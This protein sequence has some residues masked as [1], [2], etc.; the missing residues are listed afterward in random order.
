MPLYRAWIPSKLDALPLPLRD[1]VRLPRRVR[2]G[3]RERLHDSVFP[4][5]SAVRNGANG[6]PPGAA[7]PGTA[8]APGILPPPPIVNSPPNGPALLKALRRRWLLASVSSIVGGAIVAAAMFMFVPPSKHTVQ[9]QFELDAAPTDPFGK[10]AP[11]STNA[12]MFRTAQA[13]RLKSK[14]VIDSAM[15]D[16]KVA[17]LSI[18]RDVPDMVAWVNRELRLST[19]GGDEFLM[20]TL[21][22]D[23]PDEGQ[24]FLNAIVRAYLAEFINAESDLRK[25]K[26]DNLTAVKNRYDADEVQRRELMKQWSKD[27]GNNAEA[28]AYRQTIIQRALNIY[29]ENSIK[30][31]NEIAQ[32]KI[33]LKS[34]KERDPTSLPLDDQTF[35]EFFAKDQT[36]ATLKKNADES[37]ATLIDYQATM[38]PGTPKIESQKAATAAADGEL[39]LRM[40]A[41]RPQAELFWREKTSRIHA[42]QTSDLQFI[43]DQK[44]KLAQDYATKIADFEKNRKELIAGQ[45]N[46]VFMAKDSA[47]EDDI[48]KQVKRE[49][50]YMKMQAMQAPRVRLIEE[51][52]AILVDPK[53]RQVKIAT[54]GGVVAFL[55]VLAGIAMW[56]FRGRRVENV[57]QIVYGLGIPLVGTVPAM[58]QKRLLGLAGGLSP[59]ELE[60]W[61]FALQ[62]AVAT[63]RTMLL[64]AARTTNLRMVM[65]TSAVAG[66]GKTSLSTQLA[67]SLA[68]AGHRTLLLDFDMRNPSAF[69]MLAAENTPGW[70]EVLRGELNV[71]E[72]IQQTQMENL[73]FIPAG[74]CDAVSLRALCQEELGQVLV[75]LRSQYDFVIVDTCPVLPVVDALLLGRHMDGVIF[76][77]LNDVSQIPKIYTATQRL[78]SLG[79]RMLGAVINGVRED[80]YGYGGYGY[81]YGPKSLR[82]KTK[83]LPASVVATTIDVIVAK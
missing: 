14:I 54:I 15:R 40:K 35:V 45:Q 75:W 76:A 29:G 80:K 21:Q 12:A 3:H 74:D 69:K 39:D 17:G 83:P 77:I 41:L 65:V 68:M 9:A 8:L 25:K 33:E 28:V 53:A 59:E 23:F 70:S 78:L 5:R 2:L 50:E 58:P 48:Y 22:T 24:T 46:L 60:Q 72:C 10:A 61:R 4:P 16:P 64:N 6:L 37:R 79:I 31:N 67:V 43:L 73:W 1:I 38:Q 13:I 66:E 44:E 51:P 42:S 52:R 7:I 34:L 27:V 11:E 19:P 36:Y 71:T 32:H 30:L 57:D 55:L 47:T 82:N 81:G 56:E 49:L 62:E 20:V 18:V 63:A 26:F